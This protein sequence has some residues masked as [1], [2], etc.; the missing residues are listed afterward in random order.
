[1]ARDGHKTLDALISAAALVG[2]VLLA[3]SAEA[4]YSAV[5]AV[6][7]TPTNVYFGGYC[8]HTNGDDCGSTYKLP[9]T[10]NFG[11]RKTDQI[12]LRSDGKVQFLD[13]THRVISEIDTGINDG[14][15]VNIDFRGNRFPLPPEGTPKDLVLGLTQLANIGDERVLYTYY[16]IPDKDFQ[17]P[18]FL[19]P[20]VDYH[21]A[22]E[23]I[24]ASWYTCYKPFAC[25]EDVHSVTLTP[26]AGGFAV[27][28]GGI[29]SGKAGHQLRA[30]FGAAVPEPSA[31][32]LLVLGFGS[33]GAV[34]RAHRK[35]RSR[36][37]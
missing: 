5:D 10:V 2:G 21:I 11:G 18:P 24:R 9:Y 31:W 20:A 23:I 27:V 28:Y 29:N 19:L 7:N 3:T 37:A 14:P 30:F 4:R 33:T 25:L 22:S 35:Q 16:P 8:D 13:S 32:A 15:V 1:M 34:L 17:F 36:L 6:G 12:L 26:N